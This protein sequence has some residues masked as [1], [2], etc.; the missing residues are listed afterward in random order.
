MAH[1]RGKS[2]RRPD[3]AYPANL[4]AETGNPSCPSLGLKKHLTY[5]AGSSAFRIGPTSIWEE[6]EVAP[7]SV[8]PRENA[9]GLRVAKGG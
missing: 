8:G 1:F 9:Q 5:C 2:A 6:A 7:P 4:G 3:D